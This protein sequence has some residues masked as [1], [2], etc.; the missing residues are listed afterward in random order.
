MTPC[1]A[2]GRELA[3]GPLDPD[4]YAGCY[5][6]G[7]LYQRAPW[8]AL[9]RVFVGLAPAEVRE[10]F[11]VFLDLYWRERIADVQAAARDLSPSLDA[12]AAAE[13]AAGNPRQEVTA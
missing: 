11:E 12:R 6:C 13:A 1:P 5:H 8:G 3:G 4:T 9:V 2:C 7:R 10:L